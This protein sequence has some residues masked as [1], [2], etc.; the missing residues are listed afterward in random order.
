[1]DYLLCSFKHKS[2]CY[3]VRISG[4]SSTMSMGFIVARTLLAVCKAKVNGI[5]TLLVVVYFKI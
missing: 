2:L 4:S 3:F 5:P 1:M